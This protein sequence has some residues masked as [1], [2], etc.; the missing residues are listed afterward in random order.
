MFNAGTF[1]PEIFQG[2]QHP[3]DH[4][5]DG[6]E[7]YTAAHHA[8]HAF[9]MDGPAYLDEI[10]VDRCLMEQLREAMSAGW[11][12]GVDGTHG[13]KVS[14]ELPGRHTTERRHSASAEVVVQRRAVSLDERTHTHTA[15]TT[16]LRDDTATPEGTLFRPKLSK[17]KEPA[18]P[19]EATPIKRARTI[20]RSFTAPLP[21]PATQTQR[22]SSDEARA[23]L[24]TDMP[25]ALLI[26]WFL[27]RI[28]N[29]KILSPASDTFSGKGDDFELLRLLA[30]THQDKR[31]WIIM[32]D[33]LACPQ[34][35]EMMRARRADKEVRY[36]ARHPR[37]KMGDEQQKNVRPSFWSRLMAKASRAVHG[38]DGRR[39]VVCEHRHPDANN[40]CRSSPSSILGRALTN[41]DHQILRQT[42]QRGCGRH[43]QYPP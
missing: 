9:N 27:Q 17:G 25:R 43:K 7:P 8:G 29:I 22:T 35:V 15:S 1:E 21:A 5:L 41:T 40:V 34:C 23:F 14:E 26:N 37:K 18:L 2:Q 13:G 4:N 3:F 30:S 33:D 20:V 42:G 32:V 12:G 28:D 31:W 11:M 16:L 6:L 39:K 24:K 19:S 38:G 10:P 36:L